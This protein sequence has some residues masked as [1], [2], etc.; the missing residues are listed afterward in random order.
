MYT[1]LQTVREEYQSAKRAGNFDRSLVR[2][3]AEERNLWISGSALGL[4]I[5]LHRFRNLLKKYHNEIDK[6]DVRVDKIDGIVRV[7][8]V[9][10]Y[11]LKL[12]AIKSIL[13]KTE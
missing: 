11:K 10:T 5:L 9:D 4:W 13:K 7:D 1:D 2:L 8:K 6:V 3:M 12:P